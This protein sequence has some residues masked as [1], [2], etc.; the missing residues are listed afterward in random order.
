MLKFPW[1]R[2]WNHKKKNSFYCKIYK[3]KQFLLKNSWVTSILPQFWESLRSPT[4]ISS[5]KPVNL[6]WVQY[7]LRDTIF[8]WGGHKQWFGGGGT[9][10]ECS[11]VAP[12]LPP[13]PTNLKQQITSTLPVFKWQSTFEKKKRN[14]LVEMLIEQVIEFES[15]VSGP[16]VVHCTVHIFLKLDIFMAKQKSP[17]QIFEWII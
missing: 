12:G 5:T 1:I 15:R 11:P 7:L 2:R 14:Y 17:R 4:A 16:L 8:G 6:F 9:T 10:S 3:K 13:L